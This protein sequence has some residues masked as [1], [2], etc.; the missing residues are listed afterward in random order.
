MNLQ[1]LVD[2]IKILINL[3]ALGYPLNINL[4]ANTLLNFLNPMEDIQLLPN[5]TKILTGIL[6]LTSTINILLLSLFLPPLLFL[7]PPS[8]LF[9]LLLLL[10]AVLIPLLLLLVLAL[11]LPLLFRSR[12]NFI[13]T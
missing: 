6:I 2:P 12:K 3:L 7:V 8:P 5:P 11:L 10:P 13:H 4:L 9:L 1:L